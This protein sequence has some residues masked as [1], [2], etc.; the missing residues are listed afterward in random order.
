MAKVKIIKT[1]WSLAQLWNETAMK[2]NRPLQQRDYIYASELGYPLVDRFLKMKAVPYTNPPNSR[3]L[4]KFAAGNVW[5][6]VVKQILVACGVYRH[7]EIKADATPY[8]GMLDVHG[9]LD[10][11]AGGIINADEAMVKVNDL[12]FPDFL[13]KTAQKIIEALAGG[14]L[15]EKILEV[16]AI[17]TFAM[18]MVEHRKA[19]IPNHTLQGF[20]YQRAKKIPAEVCYICKDDCRMAQFGINTK[21]TEP[22]YRADI[23]EMT[24]YY[25]ADQRPPLAPLAT[26]D[27]SLAKFSKNLGVEYSPYL[28]L[29]YGFETPDDYRNSVTFV[30]KWNRSLT[31]FAQSAIGATTPTGKP[32]KITDKNMEVKEEIQEA[33]YDFEKILKAKVAAG[34][35]DDEEE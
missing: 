19:P 33:G 2:E 11:M 35:T 8:E 13:V 17:S 4:R 27:W 34:A 10:F 18:D 20:H 25:N 14:H 30:E 7:E 6:Y 15:Q 28:T 22:L 29:V 24:G 16:K 1:D 26:F 32:I 21:E 12:Q 9:R 3:S 5:E 31:R 23:E